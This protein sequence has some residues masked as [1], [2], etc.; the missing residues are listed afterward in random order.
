MIFLDR[1]RMQ[2]KLFYE[3]V[4]LELNENFWKHR[5]T[6]NVKFEYGIDESGV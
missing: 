5:L 3:M 2:L 4:C 6:G 1:K